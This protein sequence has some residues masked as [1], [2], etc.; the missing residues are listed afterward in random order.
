MYFAGSH[1]LSTSPQ[2]FV[3]SLTMNTS[4]SAKLEFS[5]GTAGTGQVWID[6]VSITEI[7]TSTM[8]VEEAKEQCPTSFALHQN[9]PNPFNPTTTIR[10]S[11]PHKSQVLLTVYNTLGQQVATIVQAQ[12]DAGSYEVKFDG[13]ALASGVYIYRIQAGSFVQAKKLLL[14]R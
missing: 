2:K 6:S 14:V 5:L 4:V 11:L 12:Q 13:S 10:Y 7:S 8:G 3:D 9:Y 1:T